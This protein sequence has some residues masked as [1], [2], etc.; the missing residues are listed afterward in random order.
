MSIN[1]H[2]QAVSYLTDKWSE[3]RPSEGGILRTLS[4]WDGSFWEWT[5]LKYIRLAGPALKDK[6]MGWM[7]GRGMSDPQ[8][9][10]DI[11]ENV[12]ALVAPDSPEKLNSWLRPRSDAER[13]HRWISFS[14][15]LVDLTELAGGKE[16]SSLP[17]TPRWFSELVLPYRYD[18]L[19]AAP[20]WERCLLEWMD[21]DQETVDFL[22]EF[23]GYC[24]WPSADQ[25]IGLF[26]EGKGGNGKNKF[27][28]GLGSML[29]EANCSAVPL[30]TFHE[31]FVLEGVV[32]K[33]INISSECTEGKPI[34]MGIVKS[35]I[36][37]DPITFD[38]KFRSSSTVYPTVKLI[39]VWNQRPKLT[40]SSE[41]FWRRLMLVPFSKD[42][43]HSPQ[44]DP[45]LAPK[46][47]RETPGI[48]N[49][50]VRGL[51]R[52]LAR[53]KFVPPKVVR[54]RASDCRDEA[55]PTRAYLLENYEYDPSSFCR[56]DEVL[57]H[58]QEEFCAVHGWP[59]VSSEVFSRAVYRVFPKSKGAR[60]R[61]PEGGRVCVFEGL[62]RKEAKG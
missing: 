34:P 38:R 57:T 60:R 31:R 61:M 48:F 1:Y 32:G 55:D 40:D 28:I 35:I 10:R 17:P 62:K 36:S 20:L 46:I 23:C 6:L 22:Q 30:E 52:M 43:E 11:L 45:D 50:A 49:W 59:V 26:L 39:V 53:G 41:G 5:G 27:C 54:R 7:Q 29:G 44:K 8:V 21:G 13:T 16:F 18:P 15:G 33:L 9:C 4:W 2:Q 37:G 25:Q 58:Y 51:S 19:A 47:I 24:L 3:Y 12:R 14:N 42:F 56:K